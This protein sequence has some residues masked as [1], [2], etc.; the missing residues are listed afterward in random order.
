M[1][2]EIIELTKDEINAVGGNGCLHFVI[3]FLKNKNVQAAFELLFT[4]IIGMLGTNYYNK[5]KVQNKLKD[6]VLEDK[7]GQKL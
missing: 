5:C 6:I 3:E 4:A 1:K 2:H 7:K